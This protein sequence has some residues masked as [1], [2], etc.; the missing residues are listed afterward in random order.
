MKCPLIMFGLLR[1]A[2]H[3]SSTAANLNEKKPFSKGRTM[4]EALRFQS[5]MTLSSKPSF[6]SLSP[7]TLKMTNWVQGAIME[8]FS[9]FES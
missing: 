6:D 4:G 3:W 7:Q 1:M 2:F 8:D 9:D 5:L